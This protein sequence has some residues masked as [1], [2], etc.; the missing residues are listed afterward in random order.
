MI[1][2]GDIIEFKNSG[3]QWI[4]LHHSTI[5]M[6]EMERYRPNVKDHTGFYLFRGLWY[7]GNLLTDKPYGKCRGQL[8]VGNFPDIKV[9]GNLAEN[10]SLKYL[11]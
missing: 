5:D 2:H 11:L 4:C 6:S 8:R 9:V 3:E 1:K 7:E 10:P